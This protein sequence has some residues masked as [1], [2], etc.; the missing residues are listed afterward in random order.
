MVS[1]S[2]STSGLRRI[3]GARTVDEVLWDNQDRARFIVE[4][5]VHATTTLVY[6]LSESGKT[7]LMADMIAALVNGESWLGEPVNGG[8]RRCL[9][10]G[11]D[12]GGDWEYAERLGQGFGDT[13][14]LGS[15]PPVDVDRWTDL[16]REAVSETVGV[17]V[18]DNLYAWAG[19][20]DTNSNAEVA[21]PLACLGA[22]AKAGLAVVLVH[23][24]NSG[25]Q[26]P[27]GVHSIPAFFRAG[28]HVT[29]TTLRSHGNDAAEAHYR[30]VRDGGRVVQ[31]SLRGATENPSRD[32]AGAPAVGRSTALQR[33][34][35][36]VAA[37]REAPPPYSERALGRYLMGRL[38][39]VGSADSGRSLVRAVVNKGMWSPPA[40]SP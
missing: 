25:G 11:A 8:P 6:G 32:G 21:R 22:L 15:P 4:G 12:A 36:A 39:D 37:L 26:K 14:M 18:V 35:Q 5:L 27:A 20:V 31:G 3:V 28:L 13:V 1:T 19:A 10:L 23:H 2:T 33:Y 38:D 16:A 7:W 30:L 29:R 9:V 24:T 34:E 40:G 17:V